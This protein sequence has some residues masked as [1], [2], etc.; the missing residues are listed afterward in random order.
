MTRRNGA[1]P[2]SY[3]KNEKSEGFSKRTTI[4]TIAKAA[5]SWEDKRYGIHLGLFQSGLAALRRDHRVAR[6]GRWVVTRQSARQAER[7]ASSTS[8]LPRS[9]AELRH[10]QERNAEATRNAVKRAYRDERLAVQG[11]PFAMRRRR[12]HREPAGYSPGK[13]PQEHLVV[14]PFRRL[15]G[16]GI[17]KRRRRPGAQRRIGR[18]G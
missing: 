17:K 10:R 13:P 8:A 1:S 5:N 6:R 9:A 2:T 14:R 12:L 18:G 7:I 4:V 3:E 11:E 16:S 15:T